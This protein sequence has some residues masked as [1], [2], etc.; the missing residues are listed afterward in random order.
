MQAMLVIL[1]IYS[2]VSAMDRRPAHTLYRDIARQLSESD[3]CSTIFQGQ[4]FEW[5]EPQDVRSVIT[6]KRAEVE[7]LTYQN[8]GTIG[9][10]EGHHIYRVGFSARIRDNSSG[11]IVE[12]PAKSEQLFEVDENN[13]IVRCLPFGMERHLASEDL[14]DYKNQPCE[15]KGWSRRMMCDRDSERCYPLSMCEK[16]GGG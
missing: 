14:H 6:S 3:Y 1:G 7:R 10:I 13:R 8:E 15:Q 4:S 2:L 12:F 16:D 9:R 11:E 5:L